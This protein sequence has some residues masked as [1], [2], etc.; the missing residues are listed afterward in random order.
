MTDPLGIHQQIK[1]KIKCSIDTFHAKVFF[2]NKLLRK[3]L[4]TEQ[5]SSHIIDERYIGK[6]V[7]PH[8]VNLPKHNLTR[9]F[10]FFPRNSN[11]LIYQGISN[12]YKEK[13]QTYGRKLTL[14][15]HFCNDEREFSEEPFT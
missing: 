2:L 10:L 4:N 12:I 11:L 14:M 1:M 13:P 5:F 9:R 6:F 15:W 8:V 7:G 3:K